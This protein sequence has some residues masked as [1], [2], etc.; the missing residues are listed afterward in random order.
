MHVSA[1]T[2]DKGYFMRITRI[3]QETLRPNREATPEGG[4]GCPQQKEHTLQRR[5]RMVTQGVPRMLAQVRMQI[6]SP[7]NPT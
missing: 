4:Q 7:P 2:S 3:H 5:P 1:V 6:A